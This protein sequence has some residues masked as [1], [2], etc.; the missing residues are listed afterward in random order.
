[1]NALTNFLP[2]IESAI[3]SASLKFCDQPDKGCCRR[4]FES[5]AMFVLPLLKKMID[6]DNRKI[7]INHEYYGGGSN[8]IEKRNLE[9]IKLLKET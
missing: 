9:L 8:V 1:M 6:E 7:S 2:G 4:S 3:K 5:G